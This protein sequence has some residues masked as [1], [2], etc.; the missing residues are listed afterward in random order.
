VLRETNRKVIGPKSHAYIAG[1]AFTKILSVVCA[2]SLQSTHCCQS[3]HWHFAKCEICETRKCERVI[4]ETPCETLSDCLS[5]VVEWHKSFKIF[6]HA[7][8]LIRL[9]FLCVLHR[10]ILFRGLPFCRTLFCKA[11]RKYHSAIRILSSF[12]FRRIAIHSSRPVSG[13]VLYI[14]V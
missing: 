11:F 6:L 13:R 12:I 10:R 8:R 7:K 4:Y 14:K 1:L 2:I 5:L 9:C 3:G